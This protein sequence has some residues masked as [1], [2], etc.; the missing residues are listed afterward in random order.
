MLLFLHNIPRPCGGGTLRKSL[1]FAREIIDMHLIDGKAIAKKIEE[2]IKESEHKGGL[3]AILVGDDDA[4]RLYVSLKEKAAARVGIHFEKIIYPKNTDEAK[5]IKKIQELNSRE[6]VTGIIVQLP[7]PKK[8]DTNKI[9]ATIDPK[10]DADGFH[11]Q[12]QKSAISPVL[13]AA[14]EIMKSIKHP[15]SLKLHGTGKN[16]KTKDKKIVLVSNSKVFPIPFQAY[17]GKNLTVCK[18]KDIKKYP[19]SADI[20]ITAIGKKHY[21]KSELVKKGAGIIDVGIVRAPG[22]GPFGKGKKIYGD[23]DPISLAKK[24]GWLTPVPGG[25]GPI[26]VAC[27]LKNTIKR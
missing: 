12:N 10:K 5:I 17:F 21:L 8:L 23:A 9:I 2:E 20:I 18:F 4:S 26:V 19:P 22:R 14:I 13:Q 11:P 27:L 6:D 25:V 7:L 1:D 15:T 24:A 16:I 3:A